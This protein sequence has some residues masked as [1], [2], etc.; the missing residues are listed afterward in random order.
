MQ[1]LENYR[2]EDKNWAN[3]S[4]HL[5]S[6]L[7]R[8][9]CIFSIHQKKDPELEAV[10]KKVSQPWDQKAV[11]LYDED[12]SL[13][14]ISEDTENVSPLK[15]D[16]KNDD[17]VKIGHELSMFLQSDR[18]TFE[19]SDRKSNDESNYFMQ[20]PPCF[21]QQTPNP[22]LESESVDKDPSLPKIKTE[23][24]F[25]EKVNQIIVM[26]EIYQPNEDDLAERILSQNEDPFNVNFDINSGTFNVNIGLFPKDSRSSFEAQ[27]NFSCLQL[28]SDK[29]VKISKGQRIKVM[30]SDG[31]SNVF[32]LQMDAECTEPLL[33]PVKNIKPILLDFPISS[34]RTY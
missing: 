17:E 1:K 3:C 10:R 28:N 9:S 15:E 25:A 16:F 8:S 7:D 21:N 11:V 14:S 30:S 24:S 32:G 4:S 12:A 34:K 23:S 26:S 5:D 20:A 18:S 33:I 19:V 22:H 27:K 29:Q 13:N 6:I 31:S 2:Y